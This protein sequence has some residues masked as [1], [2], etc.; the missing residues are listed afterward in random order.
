MIVAGGSRKP[1]GW[2]GI[3]GRPPR[4]TRR[5]SEGTTL[6]ETRQRGF[7]RHSPRWRRVSVASAN[8]DVS[9]ALS[10][11][12]ARIDWLT[13][14]HGNEVGKKSSVSYLSLPADHRKLGR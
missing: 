6:T 12:F 1:A 11:A 8:S 7:R 3:A 2:S 13:L 10:S 14:R 9:R 5:A 4:P